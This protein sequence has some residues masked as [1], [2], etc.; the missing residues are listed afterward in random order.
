M[1][2]IYYKIF[3]IG[4]NYYLGIFGFLKAN[5][6]LVFY[7]LLNNYF[8]K[9][10]TTSF[11]LKYILIN[12]DRIIPNYMQTWLIFYLY[13]PIIKIF[14]IIISVSYK[15]YLFLIGVNSLH[16]LDNYNYKNNIIFEVMYDL[17]INISNILYLL[18]EFFFKKKIL[19]YIFKLI[20]F[21]VLISFII[22]LL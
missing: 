15:L 5:I 19:K 18:T 8:Y 4:I 6:F 14:K 20:L 7:K 21:Y 9:I 10:E 17:K 13:I 3:E 12:K 11:I 22:I 16:S 2:T 1:R